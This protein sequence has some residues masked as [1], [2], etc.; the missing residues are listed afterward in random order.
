M[1][2]DYNTLFTDVNFGSDNDYM[3]IKQEEDDSMTWT[4]G[5]IE[6]KPIDWESALGFEQFSPASFEMEFPT[7]FQGQSSD[8]S[9]AS[10]TATSSTSTPIKVD[11]EL[12]DMELARSV[13]LAL[14]QSGC[15]GHPLMH[16][17]KG[18]I[19]GCQHLTKSNSSYL[20]TT[21]VDLTSNLVA[22]IQ[23]PLMPHKD[24]SMDTLLF[25]SIRKLQYLYQQVQMEMDRLNTVASSLISDIESAPTPDRVTGA[26]RAASKALYKIMGAKKVRANLPRSS[27][28]VLMEWLADNLDD[29]YPTEA[30]KSELCSTTQLSKQ[31]LNNWFVNARRRVVPAAKKR[32][33][34]VRNLEAKTGWEPNSY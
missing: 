10:A 29:P 12:F 2:F 26:K 3:E 22:E 9:G 30:E 5:M 32:R 1:S 6:E 28:R 33:D 18:L 24:R 23:G 19:L 14:S 4:T 20:Q 31:Q 17:V 34:L 21:A 16:V 11:P 15:G 8:G 27:V 7:A 25:E 13:E